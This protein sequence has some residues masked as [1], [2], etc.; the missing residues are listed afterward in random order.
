M[1]RQYLELKRRHAGC[2]LL[3]RMGDFFESF[4]DD[5]EKVSRILGIA[6]TARQKK[7]DGTGIPL[8]GFPHHALDGYLAR[9]LR[10]GCRVAVCEQMED[11]SKARG[12]VQRDVIE[13]VT[14]GTVIHGESLEPGIAA[15]LGAAAVSGAEA[16]LVLCDLSTGEIRCCSM[17]RGVLT[18]ELSRTS[19]RELLLAPG[20]GAAVP[21]GCEITE[22]EAWKFDPDHGRKLVEQRFGKGAPEGFGISGSPALLGAMGALLAYIE[23]T[24]KS[25]LSH[26]DFT[27]GYRRDDSLIMDGETQLSLGITR[28]VP[29]EEEAVLADATDGT[30]TPGG[31][32]LWREWLSAPSRDPGIISMRHGAVQEVMEDDLARPL[33]AILKGCC[34]LARQAGR[35]GAL[36]SGPRDLRAVWRTA[37]ALPEIADLVRNADNPLL[38]E[39]AE[40]DTLRD[41]AE[42]I[43]SVLVFDPPARLSDGGAVR[44]GVDDELDQLR[45]IRS[46]GRD[47]MK[48]MLDREKESAGISRM[49]IGYNKVFGYYIEVPRSSLPQVPESWTRRQTLV[50]A[51]RFVTPELKE[52]EGRILRADQE[53]AALEERIFGDLRNRVAGHVKR[54]SAAARILSSMDVLSS[55]AATARERGWCR[56]ELTEEPRLD[57]REGRHPVL[58]KLLP[59]G[60]CVPNSILLGPGRR[61]LLV[62]GPNMAGKSTI[63]RQAALTLVLAQAGS[64]VPAE[65]MAFSPVDRLF[66]RIG[67]ADR[68]TRGQSTFL[69][70]M[71]QAA[72][73]LNGSTSRS[74]A[75]LDE[76]GR[77]TSTFDGLSL[78][79][80]MLEYLH[81][82]REHRPLVL[83]ATHY[84]ELTALASKLPEAANVNVAVRETG[85]GVAFL[86]RM[87]EGATDRSYGIHVA[88][89]AGVPRSVVRRAEKVMADL[90]A[91][92]HLLPSGASG[93]GQLSL[94]LS[95]PS[96]PVL[97]E[98]AGVD[99]DALT[100]LKAMEL[101]Y[102]LREKLSD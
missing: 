24:K 54:I 33:Q 55:L 39:A 32:R 81:D 38:R 8:A 72:A 30:V 40:M 16:A 62:T 78:A 47:W 89:M 44:E 10:A 66:T 45:R 19:P 18:Q 73:I 13:V 68:L 6:L 23:E 61:I 70:E 36:R 90:E 98:I 26:L 101:V 50:G 84:H 58:E 17:E 91:G 80:S 88:S 56:P 37:E 11:P 85:G 82:H 2:L 53:T 34:D 46:G 21:P 100:P 22:T 3:F 15:L 76:V 75:I 42:M 51:E 77:G 67:G 52:W 59:Q 83:F 60:E 92:R 87:E 79:W 63:L 74:L 102:R 65:A 86:Y 9:L 96:H 25:G 48:T 31:A 20:S 1:M 64:F 7:E 49:S 43:D 93:D 4:F 99:P 97:E 12:L 5:A 71:A 28:G 69:V 95:N 29:G 14:P 41:L 35:L 27:G 94:P 57:I